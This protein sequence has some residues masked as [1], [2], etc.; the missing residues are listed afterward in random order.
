MTDTTRDRTAGANRVTAP[1]ADWDT[2]PGLLD[3]AMKLTLGPEDCDLAYW[4][5]SVAQGTLRDRG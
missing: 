2:A 3:G 1:E 5:T 4:I